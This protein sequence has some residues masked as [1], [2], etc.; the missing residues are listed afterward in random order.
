MSDGRAGFTSV[1]PAWPWQ[2]SSRVLDRMNLSAKTNSF[3][4]SL[5]GLAETEN[6][7]TN[8]AAI[9]QSVVSAAVSA[10]IGAG[11]GN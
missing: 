1:T 6:T 4:A 3:T 9:V 11:R 7:S 5:R 8:A 2:D 10:A